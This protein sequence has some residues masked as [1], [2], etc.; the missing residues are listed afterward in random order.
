[1]GRKKRDATDR[2]ETHQTKEV[3]RGTNNERYQSENQS[4]VPIS[5]TQVE[6]MIKKK[7]VRTKRGLKRK[8]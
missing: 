2:K 5:E 1:L 8:I 3:E 4:G 6:A 7:L